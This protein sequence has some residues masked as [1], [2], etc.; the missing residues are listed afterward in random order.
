M[1]SEDFVKF[2]WQ[3]QY[4]DK[5]ALTTENGDALTI[6]QVGIPNK[7]AGADFSDAKIKI[8]QT[9]WA[10]NV[11]IHVKSSDWNKHQH[12]SDAAY[13][14][15]ILHVVWE[16]DA[17]VAQEN[18][19]TVPT[20][21]L[22]N[23]V[24]GKI[25]KQYEELIQ[26]TSPIPCASQIPT[27][28]QTVKI[29]MLHQALENRLVRKKQNVV[30]LFIRNKKSW[31]ETAYQLLAQNFGFKVNAEPM[32]LLAQNIPLKI[33][34]K[35]RDNLLSIEA[36]LFGC[37]GLLTAEN[38]D[39]YSQ[40]LVKEYRFLAQKYSLPTSHLAHTWKFARIRPANF[41]TIRIAQL[42]MLVF[43]E[44]NFFALFLFAQT[45]K[46]LAEILSIKQSPYWQTHYQFGV[47]SPEK[48]AGLGDDSI[49]NIIINT[50]VPLLV[51]YADY[52]SEDK[53][54][55]KAVEWLTL[56][57]A[58]RNKITQEWKN[59][60]MPTR[61][62]FESQGSIELYNEFCTR[63]QCLTCQIGK[64]ILKNNM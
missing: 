20:L 12:Q 1:V 13:N 26:N 24:S 21:A 44:E 10:G 64:E 37:A 45:P 43:R 48:I 30:E 7:N 36:L 28:K 39:T 23:K 58:E 53:Y 8:G 41:P 14:T 18:G 5:S 54:Y 31:E 51:A 49:D 61:T 62:A 60:E 29:A 46:E 19:I 55:K 52:R 38:P 59:I 22:Q 2:L 56:L 6:F 27:I 16:H 33:L 40:T 57:K 3:Y 9:Q 50:I 25:V 15:V 32:L 63:K 11:E 35:H 47:L 42:A 4:F 17:E 34:Q